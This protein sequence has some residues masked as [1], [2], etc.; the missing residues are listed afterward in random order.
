MLSRAITYPVTTLARK[1]ADTRGGELEEGLLEP[2]AL[3]LDVAGLRVRREHRPEGSV[4]IGA[5]EDHGL[6]PA[7][8]A[9]HAGQPQQ[10]GRVDAGQRGPQDPAADAGLDLGGRP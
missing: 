9:R 1:Y 4:G 3:H 7:L 5:G 2:G 8:G 10:L 6:A